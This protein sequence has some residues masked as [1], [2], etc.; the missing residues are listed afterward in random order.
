MSEEL[1]IKIGAGARLHG[2]RY[3]RHASAA[4]NAA[5]EV[6]LIVR[7]TARNAVYRP[8]SHRLRLKSETECGGLMQAL[9]C[10]PVSIDRVCERPAEAIAVHAL[11]PGQDDW[12]SVQS[13]RDTDAVKKA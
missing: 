13:A 11:V 12:R 10:R 4:P 6:H 5:A 8:G 3:G 1:Q 2:N 7:A 9:D